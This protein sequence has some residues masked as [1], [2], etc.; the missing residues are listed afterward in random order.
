MKLSLGRS[1]LQKYDPEIDWASL[2]LQ[3]CTPDSKPLMMAPLSVAA[4]EKMPG[5]V[6]PLTD[7][8]GPH[9]MG[10][11]NSDRQANYADH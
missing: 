10:S 8:Q 5:S 6:D 11:V 3:C 4:P 1:W 2:T 7:P 9:S